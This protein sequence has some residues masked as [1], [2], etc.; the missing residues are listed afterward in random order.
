MVNAAHRAD[1]IGTAPSLPWML[2][3][4]MDLK[5]M[6]IVKSAKTLMFPS[7]PPP[8]LRLPVHLSQ[9]SE[10][11]GHDM[12]P[13]LRQTQEGDGEEASFSCC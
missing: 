13:I 10:N 9:E 12:S 5:G 4:M 1:S 2:W 8:T 3:L 7:P 6:E 11:E